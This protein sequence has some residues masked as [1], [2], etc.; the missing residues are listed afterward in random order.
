MSR[1]SLRLRNIRRAK[2]LSQE[3]LARQLGVSRQ[4]I[5][6]LEQGTSLPSLPVVMAL[7]RALDIPFTEL[8]E[9]QWTPFRQFEE[10]DAG[11]VNT[12]AHFRHGDT[13][14][15]I[16]VHLA[17]DHH[18]LYITAEL[19]GV[20]EEDVAVDLSTQHVLIMAIKKP[21]FTTMTSHIQDMEYGPLLRILPLPF[22]ID[23]SEAHA[24]FNRGVLTLTLPK[25]VPQTKRR[26]TFG[27]NNEEE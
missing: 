15:N 24:A 12:L 13:P 1:I 23:A 11:D 20:R 18:Q 9:S 10:S 21:H 2:N 7:L 22:P 25:A 3:E 16:P 17:E 19:P 26:I 27:Q 6:A 4:A 8:F 5:I 14:Q